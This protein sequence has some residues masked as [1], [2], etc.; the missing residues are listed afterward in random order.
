MGRRF[1]INMEVFH[2]LESRT[3]KSWSGKTEGKFE[4]SEVAKQNNIAMIRFRDPGSCAQTRF[5][6]RRSFLLIVR[7]RDESREFERHE[8]WSS[9]I[10]KKVAQ[11]DGVFLSLVIIFSSS[12]SFWKP[13]LSMNQ[14]VHSNESLSRIV[15]HAILHISTRLTLQTRKCLHAGFR[16]HSTESP[17]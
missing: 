7:R 8:E 15:D 14:S 5:A 1:S 17:E 13:A 16:F 4:S 3:I 11:C 12:L 9:K 10:S 2:L 6:I